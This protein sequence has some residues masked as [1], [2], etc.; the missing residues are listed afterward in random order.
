M[1]LKLLRQIIAMSKLSLY[2]IFLQCFFCSLLIAENGVAQKV[3]IEDVYVSM[4]FENESLEKVFSKIEKETDFYFA[5]S[6][7]VINRDQTISANIKNQSLADL[8]RYI[9]KDTDLMFKRVDE[10]IHV[11]KKKLF[12]PSIVEE[13]GDK[14]AF[15]TVVSGTVKDEEDGSP[16]PGRAVKF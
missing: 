15:Q 12:S 1:K 8:L 9:S 5:Y 10:N 14:D 6:K 3:S 16:L 11:S 13:F 7:Y 2:G 4:N